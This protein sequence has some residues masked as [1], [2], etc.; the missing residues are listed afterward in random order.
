MRDGI[1]D[2]AVLAT[3]VLGNGPASIVHA[4]MTL[5]VSNHDCNLIEVYA[6]LLF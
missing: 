4:G 2:V 3:N 1:I 5:C 6:W